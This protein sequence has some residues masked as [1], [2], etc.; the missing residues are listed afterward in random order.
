MEI[1]LN[2]LTKNININIAACEN[3]LFAI[4]IAIYNEL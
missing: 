3:Y 1:N 4:S 2:F